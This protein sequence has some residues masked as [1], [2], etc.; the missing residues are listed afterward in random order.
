MIDRHAEMEEH[1]CLIFQWELKELSLY[2]E[3][4]F[5]RVQ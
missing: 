2:K 5:S 4:K 3:Y 1:R